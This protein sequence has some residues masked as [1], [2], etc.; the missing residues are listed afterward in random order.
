MRNEKQVNKI[1]QWLID[2]QN[3]PVTITAMAH[4][5]GHDITFPKGYTFKENMEGDY[6]LNDNRKKVYNSYHLMVGDAKI[7]ELGFCTDKETNGFEADC[8][9][10]VKFHFTLLF[11]FKK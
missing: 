7:D 3:K 10:S 8:K 2:N 9:I 6:Y 5:F 1:K 11:N 4:E